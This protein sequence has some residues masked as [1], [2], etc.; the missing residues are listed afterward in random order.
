M[1]I[2]SQ[3]SVYPLLPSQEL[4]LSGQPWQKSPIFPV[5]CSGTPPTSLPNLFML[6][7]FTL[8]THFTAGHPQHYPSHPGLGFHPVLEHLFL[9]LCLLIYCHHLLHNI[10][11]TFSIS[12]FLFVTSLLPISC[13]PV[14]VGAPCSYLLPQQSLSSAPPYSY[15]SY[16]Q[17]APSIPPVSIFS[18]KHPIIGLQSNFLFFSEGIFVILLISPS[19]FPQF[20]PQ[21]SLLSL[22]RFLT[23]AKLCL[24]SFPSLILSYTFFCNTA[25]FSQTSNSSQTHY[26]NI[27]VDSRIKTKQ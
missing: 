2:N 12:V 3:S 13:P 14:G 17:K 23:N 10:S 7:S 5:P 18:N 25:P 19:Q 4:P 8:L 20:P 15:S 16:T 11:P 6:H 9:F 24:L 22:S 1:P 21:F 26:S 27:L